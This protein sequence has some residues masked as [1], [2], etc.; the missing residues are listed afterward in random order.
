MTNLA[1]NLARSAKKHPERPALR[2]GDTTLSYAQF[3]DLAARAAGRMAELGVATGDRVGLMLPNILEFPVLFHGALRLG[4]IVVP[5][6]PLL[7]GR[8]IDHY[9]LDSG[10]RLLWVHESVTDADLAGVAGTT[11]V[12]RVDGSLLAGLAGQAPVALAERDALDTAVILYTSGTTGTPKGAELTHVGL[13]RNQRIVVEDLVSITETDVLM[14]CLPLFHVFGLT[15]G[16]NAAVGSGALLT[17]VPRFDPQ[18]VV[19][20]IERDGVTIFQGVP[21]MYTALAALP[22]AAADK[23]ATLRICCSGG[24]SLPSEVLRAFETT[25]GAKVLEGYGLS[26][27]SPVASFNRPTEARVGSIGTPI[28]GVEFKVVDEVGAEVGVGEVGEIW[29]RGHNVMKGY[30][31]RPDATAE[32]IDTE[33][34]FRSGDMGRV[35]EDGFYYIVDRKKELIIR[36]GFN[37]YPKEIEEIIYE[38]PAIREAAVVGVPHATHGEEVGAA[39]SLKLGAEVTTDEIAAYV[40]ERVAAYKYPRVVWVLDD[41]PKG[42]TGKILKR[43]IKRPQGG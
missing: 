6:N 14:G 36:G 28:P 25:Y 41:L 21:T 37:V 34:W 13:D 22:L 40:K 30:W 23:V 27:T 18:L 15:C 1:V 32:A 43:A 19:D 4:A 31:N 7:R 10:M 24:A 12:H 17:L 11:S 38:H 29:I 2:L 8:E 39:V 33:G 5:M 9:V 42:A 35:D 16:L 20:I 26:E 3:D